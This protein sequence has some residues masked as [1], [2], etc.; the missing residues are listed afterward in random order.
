M[1]DVSLEAK[2]I[3]LSLFGATSLLT[4]LILQLMAGKHSTHFFL[5]F[6]AVAFQINVLQYFLLT[7]LKEGAARIHFNALQLIIR[8][9]LSKLGKNS[10]NDLLCG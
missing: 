2:C 1:R 10:G 4:L 6:P 8:V 7:V 9:F 5:K 3:L